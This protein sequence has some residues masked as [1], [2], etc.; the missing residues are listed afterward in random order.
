MSWSSKRSHLKSY[1]HP[2]HINYNR[3]MSA[4]FEVSFVHG[5]FQNV[6]RV[7]WP[8]CSWEELS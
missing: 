3:G 1:F 2:I 5:S 4:T 7:Y 6:S 8:E